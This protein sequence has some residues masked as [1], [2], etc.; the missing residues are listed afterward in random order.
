MQCWDGTASFGI[1]FFDGGAQV[2]GWN[3]D[4]NAAPDPTPADIATLAAAPANPAAQNTPLNAVKGC[5]PSA[6]AGEAAFAAC[7]SSKMPS[8]AVQQCAAN[9]NA[10]F[11]KWDMNNYSCKAITGLAKK[12]GLDPGKIAKPIDKIWGVAK[13]ID[14]VFKIF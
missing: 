11:G 1:A 5:L 8:N 2:N 14:K 10:C 12:V 4:P 6:G 3:G 9:C 7:I 13:K